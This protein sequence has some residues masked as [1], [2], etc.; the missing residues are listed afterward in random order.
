MRFPERPLLRPGIRIT[1]RDQDHLQVGLD[2]DLRVVVPDDAPTRGF[3]DALSTGAPVA[4]TPEVGQLA[5]RL[6]SHGL[7]IDADH[8]RRDLAEL[9]QE[10][11]TA[12]HYATF[13]LEAHDVLLRRG[14][15]GARVDQHGPCDDQV[16]HAEELLRH[17]GA[18]ASRLSPYAVL[19]VAAGVPD[20]ARIDDLVREERPHLLVSFSEGIV[21]VGPFVVP[22]VTACLR[23]V[24]AHLG[25]ADP[26]RGLVVE[27]YTRLGP[28]LDGV[29]EPL[30]PAVAQLAV[31]WAAR[32][33][34]SFLDDEVPST[35][36]TTIRFGPGAHQQRSR[37]RRHPACGCAWAQTG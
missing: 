7:L 33:L 16:T 5:D 22:G 18:A 14:R 11:A 21:V 13:G 30:D 8:F 24:D 25:D 15:R 3:L 9:S 1:R 36:S 32:D 34:V 12:A 10:S 17:A 26:R 2:A 29:P 37:W 31:A 4:L 6:L 20:R 28:R 23:C 27:Q 19:V 35:W